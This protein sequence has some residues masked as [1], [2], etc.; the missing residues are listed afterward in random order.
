MPQNVLDYE[1]I[2]NCAFQVASYYLT[3]YDS[4]KEIAQ[5][6]AIECFVNKEYLKQATLVNWVY[7]VAKNKSL[8]FIKANRQKFNYDPQI[9]SKITKDDFIE[10][11]RR[12]ELSEILSQ[13]PKNIIN[14][15]DRDIL[16]HALK[17]GVSA[18]AKDLN[19]NEHSFRI[20]IYRLKQEI[21]LFQK[22]K[23]GMKRTDPIPGTK[24]HHNLMHCLKKIKTSLETK[25]FNFL[26]EFELDEKS[27]CMLEQTSINRIIKYQLDILKKNLYQVFVAFFD[28]SDNIN[29]LRFQIIANSGNRLQIITLP[30][31]PKKILKIRNKYIPTEFKEKLK[32][33]KD[34]LI[35]L[36]REELDRELNSKVKKI[37]VVC[38]VKE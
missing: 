38:D 36:S 35:P 20:K 37:E 5:L 13:I 1:E 12:E 25:D 3:D 7:T 23:E 9:L 22:L 11:N 17:R 14:L 2:T 8:N 34:G 32:P 29:S 16:L 18:A 24:L 15:K 30:E 28:R 6:T 31:L 27:I 10:T 33:G 26:S 19:I 4:A 21:I